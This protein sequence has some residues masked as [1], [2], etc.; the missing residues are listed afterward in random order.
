MS[1]Y[2]ASIGGD[3]N[4]VFT[5]VYQTDFNTAWQAVLEA[6]KNSRLDVSNREAGFIQTRWADNTVDKNLTE[7]YGPTPSYQKAQYR[8]RVTV[9]PG[10]YEGENAVRIAI[11]KEQL[12]QQD[13]LEGWRP[14]E[15]DS[16]EENTLHYRIGRIIS[17]RTRLA[18]IEEERTRR[19][20]ES[21]P[22]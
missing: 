2:K 1:A 16:I 22:F 12:V 9:A 15:T 19:A 10:S 17:I 14:K 8:F 6:L 5:R 4:R 7:S 11:Q 21:A 20:I 18:E 13:V 3:A